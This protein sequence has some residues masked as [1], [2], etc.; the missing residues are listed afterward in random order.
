MG[1]AADPFTAQKQIVRAAS[2]DNPDI[3]RHRTIAG[4][5]TAVEADFQF[6]GDV[7]PAQPASQLLGVGNRLTFIA[8]AKIACFYLHHI[9]DGVN[10]PSRIRQATNH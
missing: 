7:H 6:L 3:F 4:H 9:A 10:R 2:V 5:R 1:I 8:I